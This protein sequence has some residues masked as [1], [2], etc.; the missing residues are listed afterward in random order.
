MSQSPTV[1]ISHL[2]R[3]RPSEVDRVVKGVQLAQGIATTWLGLA[4]Q[5]MLALHL[6]CWQPP[7]MV[8]PCL[9]VCCDCSKEGEKSLTCPENKHSWLNTIRKCTFYILQ[10]QVCKDVVWI[11]FILLYTT[12]F[13]HTFSRQLAIRHDV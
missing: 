12:V 11:T 4:V 3:G 1:P 7:G 13:M 9:N 10:H 6:Q 5:R 2:D 8:S